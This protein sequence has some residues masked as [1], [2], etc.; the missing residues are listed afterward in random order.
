MGEHCG[1]EVDKPV[2]TGHVWVMT[3]AML[4][5]KQGHVIQRD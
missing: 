4:I 5:L 2:K 1:E 3:S